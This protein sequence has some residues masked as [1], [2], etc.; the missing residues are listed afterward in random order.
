MAFW[1]V[2]WFFYKKM[3]VEGIENLPEEPA[4]IV[5]NHSKMNGP[6]SCELYFPGSHYTW[7]IA[8]MLHKKDVAAYAY[9]DFWS[10]KP[11]AV[12]WFYRLLSHLIGP[13]AEFLLGNSYTIGV[14][15]DKRIVQT[16]R[17][18]LEKMEE[19]ASIIIFPEHDVPH[20]NIV[21]EFQ[22]GFVDI[23]RLYYRK[24]GRDL[25]F[26]PLY[27]CP[28]L[29]KLV[30]GKPVYYD[31]T[32]DKKAEPQRIARALMDAVSELAY[33]QPPHTVI[34]YPNIPKKDYP[35]NEKTSC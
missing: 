25:P 3:T 17:E 27:V 6:I 18:S 12:R 1:H 8:E 7:C 15:H 34:P 31:H 24:T 33:E 22:S 32:A 23:A 30:I 21:H 20:N 35:T 11:I 26:V 13:L 28:A 10:H 2:I 14:Y 29:K 19:G 5:G 9:K 16:F 4:C